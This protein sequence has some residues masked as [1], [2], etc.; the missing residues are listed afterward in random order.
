MKKK[1][2]FAF[3]VG[4]LQSHLCAADEALTRNNSYL[5][6]SN[7]PS[8]DSLRVYFGCLRVCF[9]ILGCI[10]IIG[11]I[12]IPIIGFVIA[13][14]GF[15]ISIIIGFAMPPQKPSGYGTQYIGASHHLLGHDRARQHLLLLGHL[16][17]AQTDVLLGRGYCRLDGSL[18]LCCV[19]DV[20]VGV[21]SPSCSYCP[22]TR[23]W[24]L[25]P[26]HITVQRMSHIIINLLRRGS[27]RDG[28]LGIVHCRAVDKVTIVLVLAICFVDAL[29]QF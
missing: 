25:Q 3:G 15:V 4:Q 20:M 28:Q 6:Q 14:I 11:C 24:M 16:F 1:R 21:C 12:C 29:P 7:S 8:E 17:N 5:Y 27:V 23:L 18:D 19:H 10:N 2:Q 9:V 26:L 22:W 13:I